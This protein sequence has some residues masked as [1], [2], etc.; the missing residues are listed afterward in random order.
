M[1]S[2]RKPDQ[3][4][5]GLVGAA[6][7]QDI[8]LLE[9]F[10]QTLPQRLLRRIQALRQAGRE[11]PALDD[12]AARRAL[13]AHLRLLGRAG[14]PNARCEHPLDRE[15]LRVLLLCNH[16]LALRRKAGDLAGSRH[17]PGDDHGR[18]R[19]RISLEWR[20]LQLHRTMG[21]A[22]DPARPQLAKKLHTRL[23]KAGRGHTELARVY[24]AIYSAHRRRTRG[25]GRPSQASRA[26]A[27]QQ[28]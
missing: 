7:A 12:C 25:R 27:D 28:G 17:A 6:R 3:R 5:P 10:P 26:S 2:A 19:G 1:E 18:C 20:C 11:V 9:G 16:H 13:L 23:V 8:I 24:S 15:Q 4:R 22:I 21:V 14:G